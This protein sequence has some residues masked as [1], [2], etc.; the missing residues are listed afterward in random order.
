MRR[1]SRGSNGLGISEPGPNPCAS[2][3]SKPGAIASDGGSRASCAMAS[4]AAC[5]IS[6]LMA[7]APTSS[8]PRKMKGKHRT[9]LTWLGKSERPVQ[10]MASGR[11]LRAS[12]GMISGVGL[13]SAMTSGLSAI[14][15]DHVGLQHVGRRQAEE[16]V[17]AVDHVAQHAL[18]GLLGI[19]RLP[20]VH[21]RVAAFV[22]DAVDVADP[23]VLALR[24][25][26]DQQIEAGDRRRTGAGGDD[27]DVGDLLAV[28]QQRIGDRGADDDG[29]AMLV[30][31]EHRDLHARLELR[32]DLEA[33]RALDVLEIDAAEGRLQRRHRLDHAL[34]GVGGDFD[35]EHVDAG[36]FLEQDRLALH[37]RLAGQRADIAE[38]EHGGAVGDHRDQI[39]AGGQR[40]RLGGVCGDRLAGGRHAR[41]I[42]QRQV[43]LVGRAAWSPG[44]QAC[45]AAAADGRRAPRNGDL[46]NR[47]T[48]VLPALPTRIFISL[49][50]SEEIGF[51][52]DWAGCE[53]RATAWTQHPVASAI[54]GSIAESSKRPRIRHP[55]SSIGPTIWHLRCRTIGN[56]AAQM[57]KVMIGL[58]AAIVIAVAGYF[59]FEF[60]MRQRIADEVDAAFA[61]VRAAR[62]QGDPRQGG[63][64]SVDPH[65]LRLTTSPAEL[66]RPAGRM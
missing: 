36:E 31:M 34:D 19:D 60:Y 29:G 22:H 35:V 11:A 59:G 24:A 41:R 13:A 6:S 52:A 64:R 55:S 43:A 44:S 9:L 56:G 1:I 3:L 20:A 63:F 7:V 45:P 53:A 15:L 57:V 8:A 49:A 65:H 51:R 16:N 42:G 28:Q 4:T 48:Y 33:L 50:L 18:V 32:L 54:N 47:T 23:D 37:H 26:R 62:R 39:G 12:S 14:A 21:Q 66:R 27:L 2:P 25:Q 46:Q 61:A 40:G 10:I 58:A 17:G 5:F 30:V 38:A